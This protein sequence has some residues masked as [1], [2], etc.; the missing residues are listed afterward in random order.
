M[1]KEIFGAETEGLHVMSPV[2]V[3]NGLERYV[4]NLANMLKIDSRHEPGLL[5]ALD[6]S[7]PFD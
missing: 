5:C 2:M 6:M 4:D 7:S 1:E 3:P